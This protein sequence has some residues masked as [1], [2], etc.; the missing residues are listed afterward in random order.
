MIVI[1]SFSFCFLNL[2]DVLFFFFFF[3]SSSKREMWSIDIEYFKLFRVEH[4]RNRDW[5]FCHDSGIEHTVIRSWEF[6]IKLLDSD[7]L[8]FQH[9]RGKIKQKLTFNFSSGCS[10]DQAPSRISVPINEFP[11]IIRTYVLQLTKLPCVTI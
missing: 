6:K 11:L 9:K 7:T 8:N 3:S 4:Q 10:F 5:S 2:I 1:G